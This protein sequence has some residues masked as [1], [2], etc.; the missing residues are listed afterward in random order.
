MLKSFAFPN[1]SR[2]LV[3]FGSGYLSSTVFSLGLRYSNT[4]RHF[5]F[6]EASSFFGTIQLAVRFL[7]SEVNKRYLLIVDEKL[8]FNLTPRSNQTA[9]GVGVGIISVAIETSFVLCD[10]CFNIIW[11]LGV[12]Y[13]GRIMAELRQNK[14]SPRVEI[15]LEA[16]L[17]WRYV[18]AACPIDTIRSS[19]T[20]GMWSS[21]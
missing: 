21:I 12:I 6:P 17:S 4:T 20:G 8:I 2:M 15:N 7:F 11:E 9:I 13:V 19:A 3:I 16:G 14:G 10:D 1:L 18:M 5:C